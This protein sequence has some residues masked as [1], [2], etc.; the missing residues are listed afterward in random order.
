MAVGLF[1]GAS[2]GLAWQAESNENV[3]PFVLF[4]GNYIILDVAVDD[5]ITGKWGFDT[6]AGVH[7]ISNKLFRRLNPR[8][9]GR[10]TGFRM[11]GSRLDFDLF[12]VASIAVGSCREESAYVVTW[13]LID[14]LGIDGLLSIKLFENHPVTLDF[15]NNQLVLESDVSLGLL[16]EKG[17]IVGLETQRYRDKSLDI[18]VEFLG[19][20]SV[21]IEMEFDTGSGRNTFLHSRLMALLGVDSANAEMEV[22]HEEADTAYY[23][24]VK[25]LSLLNAPNLKADS[26][27]VH[28]KKDLIYDGVIGIDFWNGKQVTVDIPGRRLI[29]RE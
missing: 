10:L 22:H 20:D 16:Q 2:P 9:A 11:D 3:I 29:V 14:S 21:L 24:T 27:R 1:V 13:D 26:V 25:S 15:K 8:P 4:E 18:F 12:Q 6:G 5:S 19:N 28:F 17:E 23:A 7:V